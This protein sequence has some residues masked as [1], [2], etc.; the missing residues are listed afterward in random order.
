MIGLLLGGCTASTARPP[1]SERDTCVARFKYYD[2]MEDLYPNTRSRHQNR[3]A[4]PPVEAAAQRLREAGCITFSDEI[5]GMAMVVPP[6]ASPPG[7]AIPPT[8]V[9]AG[10]VTNMADD[11]ASRAF[12]ESHGIR[13]RGIGSA[14]LGRRIYIGPFATQGA[15]DDAMALA[16][17]AGF[18]SPYPARF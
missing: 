15:L 10:V 3:V 8:S 4:A 6:P 16:L 17:A 14:P 18:E 1:A 11:A 12:F 2:L 13:A 5:A 9:H 7:A